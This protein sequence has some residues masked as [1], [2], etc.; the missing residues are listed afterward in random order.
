MIEMTFKKKLKL[1]KM[2]NES[3]HSDVITLLCLTYFLKN[4]KEVTM[5]NPLS[6]FS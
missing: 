1:Y 4:Y 3:N 2:S 5:L 6:L